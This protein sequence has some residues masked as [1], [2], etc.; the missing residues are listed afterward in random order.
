MSQIQPSAPLHDVDPI[1]DAVKSAYDNGRYLEASE[2]GQPLGE[3]KTWPV[4]RGRNL[5]ARLAGNLGGSRLSSSLHLRN[6][7]QAPEDPGYAL[8]YGYETRSSYGPWRTWLYLNERGETPF[9]GHDDDDARARS[10]RLCADWLALRAGL[11]AGFR[12]FTAAERDLD[13]AFELMP[14]RPWLMIERSGVLLA[15]D[16]YEE[17]LASAEQALSLAPNYRPAVQQVGRC[18]LLLDR[19]DQAIDHLR[20]ATERLQCGGLWWQL[21]GLYR[22]TLAYDEEADAIDRA[23]ALWPLMDKSYHEA[24]AARRSDIAYHRGDLHA[25]VDQ[26]EAVKGRFFKVVRENM[27]AALKSE[28]PR[29]P[30]KLLSLPFVRQH[31]M[32]CA[33][34]TLSTIARY[35][36]RE[37]DHLQITEEICYDGTPWHSER[38]WAE[39]NGYLVREF[40]VTPESAAACIERDLPFTLSTVEADNAHLQ[41]VVGYDALRQTV[42]I[43]DPYNPNI[44]EMLGLGLQ[45]R[46]GPTGPRGMLIVPEDQAHRLDGLELPDVDEYHHYFQLH[47]ALDA[48]DREAAHRIAQTLAEHAPGHNLTH[49][50]KL[51]LAAYDADPAGELEAL[52][53]LLETHPDNEPLKMRRYAVLQR[54]ERR[55]EA[56]EL[57][58]TLVAD[59]KS[60]DAFRERL[61]VLL[62]DDARQAPRIRALLRKLLRRR[63]SAAL[64]HAFACTL[65][66]EPD[67][68]RLA[69]DAYGFAATLADKNELYADSYFVAQQHAGNTDQ[70]LAR[71]GER[72]ERLGHKSAQPVL[73]YYHALCR[74]NRQTEAL[75]QLDFGI[76]RRPTDPDLVQLAA[77]EN[78]RY[79][80]EDR[81]RQLIADIEP[82]SRR[83]SWLRVA[84][85][86]HEM[87]GDL[88]Q[89]LEHARTLA[90]LEPLNAGAHY[91]TAS[92]LAALE[93][94]DAGL[95]H[96]EAACDRF[97][98]RVD[99]Q[100]T[101]HEWVRPHDPERARRV[102][103]RVIELN[104]NYTWAVRQLAYYC[105]EDQAIDEAD[106]LARTAAELEP[107]ND[108]TLY[109]LA[110]V[111][112]ARGDADAARRT[113]RQTLERNADNHA[114][115]ARLLELSHDPEIAASS[116][117]FIAEQFE[118]QRLFG[119]GLQSFQERAVGLMRD[120]DLLDIL[121]RIHQHRPDLWPAW[122]VLIRQH[123]AMDQLD[124][125]AKLAA[126]AT[127]RFPLLPAVWICR[128]RVHHSRLERGE[129]ERCLRE[130]L[131]INPTA[132]FA[133]SQ[134]LDYFTSHAQFD[135]ALDFIEQTLARDPRNASLQ[136]YHARVR[137]SVHQDE[138]CLD[139]AEKALS[140][141]HRL[142][143][144][145]NQYPSWAEQLNQPDR[146]LDTCR[147]LIE[148]RPGDADLRLTQA[149]LLHKPADVPARLAALDEAVRLR[150]RFADAH[151]QRVDALATLRRFD[152]ARAAC[153]PPVFAGSPPT[154]LRGRAAWLTAQ[155]GDVPEAIL[156]M[157]KVV[158]DAP[159]YMWGWHCLAHWAEIQDDKP[160]MRE[161]A[162]RR[163][164]LAPQDPAALAHDAYARAQH[165]DSPNVSNQ[166]RDRLRGEALELYTRA[167]QLDP[168]YTN[169]GVDLMDLLIKLQRFDEAKAVFD[170]LAPHTNP[171]GVEALRISLEIARKNHDDALAAYEQLLLAPG[172]TPNT[173]ARATNEMRM[174]CPAAQKRAGRKRIAAAAEHPDSNPLAAV[175]LVRWKLHRQQWREA[176]RVLDQ[177]AE[178][179]AHWQKAVLFYLESANEH[180]PQK[181]A[182]ASLVRRS[183][184]RFTAKN[185]A[186]ADLA[187]GMGISAA[188][189]A[190]DR[191]LACRISQDWRQRQHLEPWMLINRLQALH[192]PRRFADAAEVG[193]AALQLTPDHCYHGL[194]VWTAFSDALDGRPDDIGEL[195]AD[196]PF[197]QLTPF[198]GFIFRLAKAGRHALAEPDPKQ[199][200]RNACS[201][202]DKAREAVPGWYRNPDLR[203]HEALTRQLIAR[204]RG[205]LARFIARIPRLRMN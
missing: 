186:D 200:Y 165:A 102:I 85:S 118:K 82:H 128:A 19:R 32:T 120:A 127:K 24:L 202:L 103:R 185:T 54:L 48:H 88:P 2:L 9:L 97:P 95:G 11:L 134:L 174:K 184:D 114:A 33:P 131:H 5:A 22:E 21:A 81:A 138:R 44:G 168:T 62:Q 154:N 73:T 157:K 40:K 141:E 43:R 87:C 94:H 39:Q 68:R 132:E 162:R 56:S 36:D 31:H 173:F 142:D 16:R 27:K 192:G 171:T 151:D 67:Q 51:S 190:G 28:A 1:I 175:E 55:D 52:D 169:A 161:T 4:G 41:A 164:E 158:V 80:R 196:V 166:E 145:W 181:S 201:V 60:D 61:I 108:A 66:E 119:D 111:Q 18:L 144:L 70:T 178:R 8:F 107:H 57:L 117:R 136:S 15:Q 198:D 197:D 113:H 123:L 194:R 47:R 26:S 160:L 35:F 96:L 46:Y 42:L 100:E 104:P 75:D 53:A 172:D 77:R 121:D 167:F 125:A 98:H 69:T 182:S 106:E 14:D 187:W 159:G 152:E 59:P 84:A 110:E 193:R 92:L 183:L 189:N 76:E 137:W 65:W 180:A 148:Q 195:L 153:D 38:H 170:R 133:V 124:D 93:S 29:P 115:I 20:Q 63:H 90:E 17:S 130:A 7:R 6:F 49:Y 147:R 86:V 72:V 156:Q 163:A 109:L 13:A 191:D 205:P 135:E 188:L 112:L 34:A 126:Q 30:R 129:Q 122:V 143:A 25:A 64:Y 203:R 199:S 45:E 146:P 12:D 3:L 150:P 116:T 37:A 89:A 101:L 71:L 58:E 99:L 50:A 10:P 179:P 91:Q 149:T 78:A 140:L 74:V 139:L 177:F 79:G 204:R 176:R 83:A 105:L 23:E 155:E